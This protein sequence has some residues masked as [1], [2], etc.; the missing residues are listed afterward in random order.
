[1]YTYNFPDHYKGDTFEGKV[2][3]LQVNDSPANL[4]D[5]SIKMDLRKNNKETTPLTLRLSTGNGITILNPASGIF[6]I[7]PQI[8]DLPTETYVYDIEVTFANQEVKTWVNGT[9]KILQDVT[10]D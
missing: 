10:H 1:M 8:I 4:L 3:T 9:W 7:D 5:A 2:F 6:Q